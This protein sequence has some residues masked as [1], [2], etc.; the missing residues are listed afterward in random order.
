MGIGTLHSLFDE[1]YYEH[2]DGG[3]LESL[4]RMFKEQIG[5]FIYPQKNRESGSLEALD[6]LS[7]SGGLQHLFEYLKERGSIT[8][9]DDISQ[10]YLDIHSP[11]VLAMINSG[12]GEWQQL[13]PSCVAD[14]IVERN[15]FGYSG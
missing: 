8:A 10:E 9:L 7:L 3:I 15:L 13:V 12:S 5:L 1:K 4:G 6:S 14:A 2:L 11:E